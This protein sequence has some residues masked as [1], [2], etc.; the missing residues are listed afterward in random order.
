M[1]NL[2]RFSKGVV[3]AMVLLW[4]VPALFIESVEPGDVGVRSSSLSGVYKTDL[5]AGWNWRIPGVHKIIMLPERYFFLD[6]TE[7]SSEGH[8]PLQIRT[9]DNNIVHIDV[10]VPVRIKPGHA[11]ELVQAGNHAVDSDGRYR[12]IRLA[13]E[14]TV[15]VLR[16]QLAE[17][18]SVGFYS[19]ARRIEVGERTLVLLNEALAELFV[20]AEG[21]L[22]RAVRFRE[23]Y[24]NQLMQIQLNEQNK[25][26]DHARE[27]VA[28][29]QQGL[30][31]FHQGTKAQASAREQDW[32]KRQADLERAYQVGFI[33]SPDST[34]GA[35]RRALAALSAGQLGEI[36]EQA[37]A[38]FGNGKPEDVGESYLLGIKNI[39]AE[40]LEYKNRVTA[41][42]DG[43]SAR[44][45]A[46]GKAREAKVRGEYESKINSLLNS[47]AGRAYVAWKSAANVTFAKTLVFNSSDGIPSVLRLR[48]FAQ[49]FMGN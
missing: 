1:N 19:T 18:D 48:R 45:E 14:T 20:E 4:I 31:N 34:P 3:V 13:Q 12:F 17:L 38:V 47:P 49:E 46:E 22:I 35:P 5:G 21:V 40:T 8:E 43:I 42:A 41:E 39:Q 9:K 30:D 44:L 32:V 24:E 10:T 7:D 11:N 28:E 16:E 23:E 36:R 29:A 15:S 27:K 37:A 25:L 2:I 33:E 26:L 6:Y